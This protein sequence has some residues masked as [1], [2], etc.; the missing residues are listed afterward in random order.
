VTYYVTLIKETFYY[1]AQK[2][3]LSAMVEYQIDDEQSSNA[4]SASSI[5]PFVVKQTFHVKG[6]GVR[7]E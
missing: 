1:I 6:D 4:D 2:K 5:H 7:I 3:Y